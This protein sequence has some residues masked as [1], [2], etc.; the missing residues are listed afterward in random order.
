MIGGHATING[1]TGTVALDYAGQRAE[2]GTRFL[3][4][5]GNMQG[6][7]GAPVLPGNKDVRV[8]VDGIEADVAY[9]TADLPED[10]SNGGTAGTWVFVIPADGKDPDGPLR[11]ELRSRGARRAV[12]LPHHAL[13]VPG[14]PGD[15]RER[16]A[17]RPTGTTGT[18]GP[19]STWPAS[20]T[21]WRPPGRPGG[22]HTA[23]PL[24][25]AEVGDVAGP[26]LVHPQC[27]FGMDTLSWPGARRSGH[28]PRHLAGR[29]GGGNGAAGRA[30]L[31]GTFL[32]GNVY[33]A[34][35][36]V[37]GRAFDIV[38]TGL[39][40]LNWL[41]DVGRWARVMA[42]L[43]APG[44]FLYLAE[45]HPVQS[46]LSDDDLTVTHPYFHTEPLEFDEPGT[47]A[48]LDAAT[49]T[50]KTYEW[51]HGIAEVL[52]AILDAGYT[53]ELFHEHDYTLFPRWPFLVKEGR[54]TYRL[55]PG[56][57]SLPLMYSLRARR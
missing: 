30:G 11:V 54:D 29:G 6:A 50:N 15:R 55:P 1:L 56:T 9:P 14:P 10:I 13:R 46:I 42:A 32:V 36:A 8:S 39:G 47:Y 52:T 48:D 23:L 45:F 25:I 35:E 3:T 2:E 22:H 53:L 4:V 21:A 28:G 27:H 51:T 40:A 20:S 7:D 5:S 31:D 38:Y 19:G 34:A 12:L 17:T 18:S 43:T 24:E 49:T 44:G 41:P 16:G 37:G 26:T 33:D 57:P